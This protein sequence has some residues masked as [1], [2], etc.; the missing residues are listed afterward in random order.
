MDNLRW[1][2]EL[3]HAEQKME[4]SGLADFT[5]GF[6]PQ[7]TLAEDSVAFLNELKNR[8]I[9]AASAFNQLKGSTVGR[10]KIY[11]ISKTEAD[12]M[13]FRFGYKMIFSL[14][15]PGKIAVSFHHFGASYIPGQEATNAVKLLKEE[16]LLVSK[17]GAFGN[18]VWTYKDQEVEIDYMVRHYL[19]WFIRESAKQ[20]I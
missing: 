19:S 7:S 9:A 13:L 4:E 3:A 5:P 6:D 12:F 20:D 1:I 15:E 2:K 16:D 14:Q 17:W 10:I 11:G 8:F 18:L